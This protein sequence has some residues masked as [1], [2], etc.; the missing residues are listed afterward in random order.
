[1]SEICS[2]SFQNIFCNE[3]LHI[4]EI[5]LT[6]YQE[7][8]TVHTAMLYVIQFCLQL[9]SGIR[10][11]L[12][13]CQHTC[14]KYTIAVRTVKNCGPG[15][16]VGIVTDLQ[17]GRSGI[18]SRWGLDFPH[19]SRSAMGHRLTDS[20]WG[21]PSRANISKAETSRTKPRQAEPNRGEPSQIEPRRTE[22]GQ[23][24]QS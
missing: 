24:K 3:T 14:M 4:W 17:T 10:I 6:Y 15:S 5:S 13:R 20:R 1:M 16:S 21:E 11:M 8:F 9:A 18:E 12:A 23:A 2:L 7:S 19:Q 22:P